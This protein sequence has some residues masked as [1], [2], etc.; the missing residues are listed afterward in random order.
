[1]VQRPCEGILDRRE[2]LGLNLGVCLGKG[3]QGFRLPRIVFVGHKVG[4]RGPSRF[5]IRATGPKTPEKRGL[6]FQGLGFRASALSP[7]RKS[8]RSSQRP[9]LRVV[10]TFLALAL[11]HFRTAHGYR[12]HV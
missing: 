8:T 6:G 5:Q 3:I 11:Y 2:L 9:F 10:P 4:S 7:T 12:G 1:M